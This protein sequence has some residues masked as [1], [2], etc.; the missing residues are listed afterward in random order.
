MCIYIMNDLDLNIYKLFNIDL[1]N[2]TDSE[3]KNTMKFME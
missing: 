1:Q 3:L 2:Y